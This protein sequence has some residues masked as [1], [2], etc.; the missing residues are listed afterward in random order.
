MTDQ[1]QKLS[2]VQTE[3]PV[4]DPPPQPTPLIV[5]KSCLFQTFK[6]W[7]TQ[8]DNMQLEGL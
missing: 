7:R 8:F 2:K 3:D 4:A 5:G 6:T 1:I